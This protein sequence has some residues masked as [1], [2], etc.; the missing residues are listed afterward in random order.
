[1]LTKVKGQTVA[2]KQLKRAKWV[3]PLLCFTQGEVELPGS[4]VNGV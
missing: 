2:V 4:A 3:T 1:L